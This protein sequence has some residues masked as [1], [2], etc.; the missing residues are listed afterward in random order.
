M[1]WIIKHKMVTVMV[2]TSLIEKYRIFKVKIR[3]VYW[4]VALFWAYSSTKYALAL[5]IRFKS[6]T[7]DSWRELQRTSLS[8]DHRNRNASTE[9]CFTLNPCSVHPMKNPARFSPVGKKLDTGVYGVKV[10]SWF[11][12]AAFI[13]IENI[14]V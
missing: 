13:W 8:V 5:L 2:G 7:Q 12:H 1:K 14:I 10:R 9:K 6:R 11:S 4:K 3:Y